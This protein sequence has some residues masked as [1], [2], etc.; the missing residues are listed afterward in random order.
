[1]TSAE[2]VRK[3]LEHKSPD[4]VPT[5]FR[6]SAP[7]D[8]ELTEEQQAYIDE[9]IDVGDYLRMEDPGIFT[10]RNG[11]K[12]WYDE[13]GVGRVYTG[14]YWDIVEFPLSDIED[15]QELLAYNW[16]GEIAPE[17]TAKMREKALKQRA[18][19][20]ATAAFG[21]WGGSTGI[22]EQSWYMR[23][24]EQFLVDMLTEPDFAE[25]L[26]DI[27]L[28]LHKKRW[29]Q[30]LL[31]VGD[32]LDIAGIGDDLS[33]QTAPLIS[34][35]LYR[36]MVKPRHKELIDFIKARTSAKIYYHCCGAATP[37][38][39]DLID[40]GVDILDP[41]QPS[42]VNPEQLKQEFGRELTFFGGVDV[43]RILPFG[44]PEQ[45]RE[46]VLKRFEQMGADGGLILGPSH[47]M[48]V[49]VPWENIHAMYEAIK[50]C[51]YE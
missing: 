50:E 45:V 5:F 22:F 32:I 17:R 43:Q 14:L 33:G 42:S 13:L 8:Q 24:L 20:K 12:L 28:E 35:Q 4:R 25:R 37:F 39:R 3:A 30:V 19:G 44:T 36:D 21:S 15:E 6:R 23:G 46:E 51:T 47:W 7:E 29:E 49:D 41:I 10:E 2:R 1:M 40:I 48:Q 31:Q 27:Q 26:L 18:A 38:V 9:I 34:P 11:K 16:P